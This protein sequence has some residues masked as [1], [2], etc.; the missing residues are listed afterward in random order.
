M[1]WLRY[2][3]RL[4]WDRERREEMDSYVQI[5][6]DENI[7]R[8]MAAEEARLAAQRKFGN[9][10]LVREEIYRMNTFQFLD[11]TLRAA[12]HALRALRHNPTF[13]VVAVLT[14]A[15]GIGANTAIFSV[16]NGVLIKPL[17]YPEPDRLVAIWHAAPG[18]GI[19]GDLNCSPSMYFTYREQN[20]V[21]QD[22]GMWQS[23]GTTVTGIGDPEQVRTLW[24]T[25]G[26]LQALRVQPFLGRWFSEA[27][28]SPSGTNPAPIILTYGYWQ[29][30]FGGDK[31]VIGRTLTVDSR[32]NQIYDHRPV[33]L[34]SE[35]MARELWGTPAAAL[36]KR[37]HGGGLSAETPWREVIG[38][39]EDVRNEG[40]QKNAPT[41]VYW[42]AFM[43]NFYG[44]P[45]LAT[46]AVVFSI[47]S[48]R[49]G[50]ESLLK[51]ASQAIWSVNGNLPVFLIRT[52]QQLYDTS[53]A[54]TSFTLVMLAIA[55]A[56][57][58]LLGIVG[59]YGVISYVVSQRTREIGIR[60]ALGARQG[61]VKRMFVRQGLVLA[62]VGI[63]CGLAASAGLTRLMTSLLFGVKPW[64]PATYTAVPVILV[65]AAVLAS[66]LPARRAAAV[67]PAETLRAE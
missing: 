31:S 24:V 51:D 29:R 30:R 54:A 39:A 38:V 43:A 46:R 1:S 33:A 17:S 44:S 13:A 64:D 63:L 40:L 32:L 23:G 18:M 61:D 10:T 3:R 26:L 65:T 67:D 6:T 16:V 34:I 2:F 8:G 60:V 15:L 41:I 20:H 55:G 7:A 52:Q 35:N 53:L 57:A 59:I 47:R 56:M 12:R 50:S 25:Y 4:S 11:S 28:D 36:G 21:F 62:S 42:P 22:V 14:L 66:Y 27:D 45:R 9:A 19:A 58:L 49:A 48:E 37:I 5:E